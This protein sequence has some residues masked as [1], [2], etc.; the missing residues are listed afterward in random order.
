LLDD[1]K[2]VPEVSREIGVT[3]TTLHK[4]I[5]AGRLHAFKKK[6]LIPYDGSPSN[7]SERSEIDSAA[8][9]GYG[10]TR[11]LERVAAAMGALEAAPLSSSRRGT[12]RKG[13]CC[14]HYRR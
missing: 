13:A 1:G 12:S 8:P 10:A 3:G 6:A 14:W 7:K 11:S 4:A 5:R 9:M 2:S